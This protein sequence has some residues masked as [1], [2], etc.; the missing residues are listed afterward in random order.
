[1][2]R[3]WKPLQKNFWQNKEIKDRNGKR[4]QMARNRRIG[5]RTGIEGGKALLC[6]FFVYLLRF[7]LKI[8]LF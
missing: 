8:G 2:W 6:L 3:K 4:F 1:M 5:F 7:G